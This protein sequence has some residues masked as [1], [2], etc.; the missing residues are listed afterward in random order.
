MSTPPKDD[1]QV[2]LTFSGRDKSY[3]RPVAIV[4]AAAGI[5]FA[6]AT[7]ATNVAVYLLPMNDLYLQVLVPV[8]ADGAEPLSLQSLA[9]EVTGKTMVVRGSVS[10]RTD[11]PVSGLVAVID[12][13]DTTSRFGQTVEAPVEP[14][15]L[16]SRAA[17][18]FM[19]MATLEEKPAGYVIKFKLADGPLVPHKDERAVSFTLP[20]K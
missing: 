20:G 10:N 12:M 8:A 4:V 11:Y 7:M 15:E 17:G 13:Q 3:A 9:Q 18:T 5:L 19:A 6:I 16:P 2:D 1:F 14:A